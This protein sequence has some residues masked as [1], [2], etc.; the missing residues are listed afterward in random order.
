MQQVSCV[1]SYLDT[2]LVYCLSLT[3]SRCTNLSFADAK[4]AKQLKGKIDSMASHWRKRKR[5]TTEFI[6][7]MEEATD[8][9]INMK[10]IAKGDGPIEIETDEAAIKGA[11]AWGSRKK[12]KIVS[13]P[14]GGLKPRNGASASSAALVGDENLIGVVLDAKGVPQRVFLN[15]KEE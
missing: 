10:K 5:I 6:L 12:A 11:K 4:Y 15:E 8:G 7:R 13:K 3:L 2:L 9:T 1:M 14:K